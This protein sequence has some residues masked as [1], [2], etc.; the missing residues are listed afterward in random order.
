MCAQ[1]SRKVGRFIRAIL[2][3]SAFKVSV[4][5]LPSYKS[6]EIP[7]TKLQFPLHNI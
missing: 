3:A 4:G 5:C 1:N 7:K 2:F 6:N